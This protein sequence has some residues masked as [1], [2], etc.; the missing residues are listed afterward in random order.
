[1]NQFKFGSG[2]FT[3]DETFR[4]TFYFLKGN[5]KIDNLSLN[6]KRLSSQLS[7]S[8]GG[9]GAILGH[10]AGQ[11]WAPPGRASLSALLVDLAWPPAATVN[12][13][14]KQI[15]NTFSKTGMKSEY[16]AAKLDRIK[17]FTIIV[18]FFSVWSYL[19]MINGREY[20]Y[21]RCFKWLY[22]SSP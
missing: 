5:A 12:N 14:K 2:P 8:W 7:P 4:I 13:K 20:L 21:C 22:E 10:P 1:M 3:A 11:G 15:S 6:S 19:I 16:Q 18:S 17:V 9:I